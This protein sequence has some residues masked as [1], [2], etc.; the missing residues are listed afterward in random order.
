[1]ESLFQFYLQSISQ[2]IFHQSPLKNKTTFKIIAEK[3][4][5]NFKVKVFQSETQF[6]K[7][8]QRQIQQLAIT[9]LNLEANL[10]NERE[11]LMKHYRRN[12][13]LDQLL[14]LQ[15]SLITL[16]TILWVTS[17]RR[18]CSKCKVKGLTL[19]QVWEEMQKVFWHLSRKRSQL[20]LRILQNILRM[21]VKSISRIFSRILFK[22]K[23][24]KHRLTHQNAW[25]LKNGKCCE[26]NPK[27]K[28]SPNKIKK[29]LRDPK[30]LDHF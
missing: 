4:F 11:S 14:K 29:W 24:T 21:Q 23:T 28:E 20:K 10:L 2:H 16:C 1:M 13:K 15:N 22:R 19:D 6:R 26:N 8:D 27:T 9:N 30:H 7:I 3:L 5:Q 18:K 25:N 12:L 17:Q